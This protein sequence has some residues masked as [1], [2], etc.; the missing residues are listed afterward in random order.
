VSAC[1]AQ[2]AEPRVSVLRSVAHEV[3]GRPLEFSDEELTRALSARNFVEVRATLGGPAPAVTAKAIDA[4]LATLAH[5]DD[6]L[7]ETLGKLNDAERGLNAVLD[8]L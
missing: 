5:D 6:W 8:Q 1:A 7:A 2:P 3:L 4:S